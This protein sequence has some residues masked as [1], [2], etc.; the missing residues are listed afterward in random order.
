MPD[1]NWRLP[2]KLYDR[3]NRKAKAQSSQKS[4]DEI[5]GALK[6]EEELKKKRKRLTI[7][8]FFRPHRD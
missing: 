6:D 2:K 1:R 8:W 7:D 5:K 3:K 4:K